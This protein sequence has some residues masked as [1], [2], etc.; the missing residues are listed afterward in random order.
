MIH[1]GKNF[2]ETYR[3]YREGKVPEAIYLRIS[4]VLLSL[5]DMG[6]IEA[7]MTAAERLLLES[8]IDSVDESYSSYMGGE[9]KLVEAVA[10]LEDI[11]YC[12]VAFA[13]THGGR[14]PNLLDGPGSFDTCKWLD[15][16]KAFVEV[17]MAWNDSGGPVWFIP[18]AIVTA[19]VI[20]SMDNT[21][22]FWSKADD[23]E[24]VV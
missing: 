20:G 6:V 17:F 16:K 23:S 8:G 5:E 15:D 24:T 22:L 9:F 21:N 7:T 10:D 14:W 2:R 4:S 1:L 12:D 19:N 13:G 11:E 18:A 3:L